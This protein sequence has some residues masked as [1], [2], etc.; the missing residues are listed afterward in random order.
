[1]QSLNRQVLKKE[2]GRDS[3]IANELFLLKR[4]TPLNFIMLQSWYQKY[5]LQ[6]SMV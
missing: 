1:M 5:R 3:R 6:A 2:I 4:N